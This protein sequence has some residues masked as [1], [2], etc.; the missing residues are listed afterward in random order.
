[1]HI[2]AH[3]MQVR[4]RFDGLADAFLRVIR[5]LLDGRAVLHDDIQIHAG[6]LG[7][8]FHLHALGHGAVLAQQIAGDIAHARNALHL[9]GG[10]AR[11]NRDHF[12]GVGD[13]APLL[14][15]HID[16]HGQ[17]ILLQRH[18]EMHLLIS[19]QTPAHKST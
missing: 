5:C 8:D 12:I 6:F 13:A 15:I 11:N 4:H 19:I 17:I 16:I 2:H 7:A 18:N 3:H 1:M 14:G 10:D 9:A